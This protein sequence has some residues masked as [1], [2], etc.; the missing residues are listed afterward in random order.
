MWSGH[1]GQNKYMNK[2]VLIETQSGVQER[3]YREWIAKT[4]KLNS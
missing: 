1:T 2:D 4:H 3:T